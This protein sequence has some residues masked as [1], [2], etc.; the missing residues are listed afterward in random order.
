MEENS[1]KISFS[2]PIEVKNKAMGLLRQGLSKN[3][4]SKELG[5]SFT[6][7]RRWTAGL[8]STYS[9]SYSEET[10]QKAIEMAKAGV[11]RVKIARDLNAGYYSV[12]S[13]TRGI[14]TWQKRLPLPLKL[15]KKA[16]KMVRSGMT[17]RGTAG[18]LNVSYNTICSWTADI[19]NPNSRLGGAAEKILAEVV[20]NGY[21]MPKYG[22]LNTCRILRQNVGLR[23]TRLNGRWILYSLNE[24]DKAMKAMLVRSGLNYLS[25]QRLAIIKRLFYGR[26]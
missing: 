9:I 25:N 2:Y 7:I 19:H 4:I 15:R 14:N 10:K 24:N 13:W 18:M 1:M 3:R 22:Q 20:E 21:F 12:L 16:R 8:D 26:R 23:L 17:K 6:T 5:I 11:N